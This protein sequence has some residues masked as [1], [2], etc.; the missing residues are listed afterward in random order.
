MTDDTPA[1]EG[2]DEDPSAS[3]EPDGGSV[4]VEP[5][6]HVHVDPYE[7]NWMRIAA[8][9]MV[10]FAIAVTVAGLALGIQVPTDEGRVDPNTLASTPP[11][12]EP[13]LREIV[14]GEEYDLYI[15]ARRFAF[16]PMEVEIPQG[17]TVNFYAT[18]ADVQHGIKL[19]LA[20]AEGRQASNINIMVIP[21]QVSKLTSTFDDVGVYDYICHEYCGL[22]HH[23]MAGVLRV[24][25]AEGGE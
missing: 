23:Q 11:W 22:A 10:V 13:G 21:G 9:T 16:Q 3:S 1:A 12:S 8:F 5:D 20:G 25:P 14:P 15:V 18:S 7:R 6:E 2:F 17:A 19:G 4:V 24:V